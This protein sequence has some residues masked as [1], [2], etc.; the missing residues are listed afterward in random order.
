MKVEC[1]CHCLVRWRSRTVIKLITP[2]VVFILYSAGPS[3]A[4]EYI[5]EATRTPV[6]TQQGT[7]SC[8]RCHSG[9]KMRSFSASRHGDRQVQGTPAAEHGCESCHGPGSIHVSRAHGGRGFPPL[10]RFGRSNSSSPRDE[11]LHACLVCHT[12]EIM[13]D[14][15]IEFIGSAHDRPNIYCSNCHTAHAETD[16]MNDKDAQEKSCSRCH[17]KDIGQHPRF[18]GKSI[19][20]E[21]LSCATCHDVHAISRAEE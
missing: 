15:R 16:P 9:E 11:Q 13:G 18:E 2:V 1:F 14:R 4:H 12:D 7:E 20:F 21:A 17:R 5:K 19:N 6:F 10:T 8:L 3:A